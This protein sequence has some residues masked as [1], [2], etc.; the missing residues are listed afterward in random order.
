MPR[1]C[2]RTRRSVEDRRG[3]VEVANLFRAKSVDIA[4]DSIMLELTG[5]PEKIDSFISLLKPFG[6]VK[7]V[8]SG[9]S[10]LERD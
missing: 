8:R 5:K 9:I 6:I 4:E 7:M 3:I 2:H 10:A 1:A